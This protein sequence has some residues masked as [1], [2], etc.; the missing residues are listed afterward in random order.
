MSSGRF[1]LALKA[2]DAIHL[3]VHNLNVVRHVGRLLD[4]VRSSRPAQMMHD[5]DLIMLI[6]RILQQREKDTVCVTKVKGHADKEMVRVGQERELDWL[7][8]NAADEAADF[9]RRRVYPAVLDARRNLPGV[10]RRWCPIILEIHRFFIA[11]SRVVVNDDDDIGTASD[12][13]VDLMGIRLR[14]LEVMSLMMMMLL[15][16][17]CIVTPLLLPY[18]TSGVVLFC[19]F[20]MP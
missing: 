8:N 5:R 2:S 3:G 6:H 17:F 15:V 13:L 14:T 11:I 7:G 10:C 16:S 19:A 1:P 20:L 12:P 18:L 4:G 9:G